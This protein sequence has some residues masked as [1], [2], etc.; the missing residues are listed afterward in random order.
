M[1]K[2]DSTLETKAKNILINESYQELSEIK[3]D[4][5]KAW[6]ED[7]S[8]EMYQSEYGHLEGVQILSIWEYMCYFAHKQNQ[9]PNEIYLK[10]MAN[11][12]KLREIAAHDKELRENEE[13]NWPNEFASSDELDFKDDYKSPSLNELDD[14]YSLGECLRELDDYAQL[15]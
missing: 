8:W 6:E 1:K 11:Q 4:I 2:H 10:K 13:W 5:Q 3:F 9:M 12:E 15:L 14:D 7:I